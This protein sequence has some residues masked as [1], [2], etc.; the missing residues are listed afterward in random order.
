MIKQFSIMRDGHNSLAAFSKLLNFLLSTYGQIARLFT[1]LG[2]FSGLF[3]CSRVRRVGIK[4]NSP[5]NPWPVVYIYDVVKRG[6]PAI[7]L[8]IQHWYLLSNEM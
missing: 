6:H 2:E 7:F 3:F 8:D 4:L 5:Y 1:M